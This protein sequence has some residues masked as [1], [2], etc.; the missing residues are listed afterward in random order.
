MTAVSIA[1]F[2]GAAAVA[3]SLAATTTCA[4]V[5]LTALGRTVAVTQAPFSQVVDRT[6]NWRLCRI[7]AA[8]P[9]EF[10]TPSMAQES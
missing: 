7:Q 9:F 3:V 1:V 8:R 10:A 2:S 4:S 6:P 5:V